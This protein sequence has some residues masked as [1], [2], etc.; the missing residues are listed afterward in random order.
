MDF[1]SSGEVYC[2]FDVDVFDSSVMSA[3]G[4]PETEGLGLELFDLLEEIK[5]KIKWF[6][7]VEYNSEL[8]EGEK[9]LGVVKK[10][11]DLMEK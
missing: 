6:D 4:Y 3:T 7:L 11:L 8:D 2:S 1:V 9:G 5:E 10:V